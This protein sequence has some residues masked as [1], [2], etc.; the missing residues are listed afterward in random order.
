M[1]I[2]SQFAYSKVNSMVCFRLAF[3]PTKML[4]FPIS[5]SKFLLMH[6]DR[7][8]ERITLNCGKNA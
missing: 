4:G 5:F 1:I 6:F 7:D 3:L 2:S 8:L